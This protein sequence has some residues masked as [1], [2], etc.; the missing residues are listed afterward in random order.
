MERGEEGL[1]YSQFRC[2]MSFYR[3]RQKLLLAG[4]AKAVRRLMLGFW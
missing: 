3:V 4:K 2:V 1:G